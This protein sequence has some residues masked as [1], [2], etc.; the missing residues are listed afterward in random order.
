MRHNTQ[1]L[2]AAV[3]ASLMLLAIAGA[4]VAGPIEDGEAARDRKD[5][6][7]AL[8]LFRSLAE[9][10][11]PTAQEHLGVMYE[12]G[13]GLPQ[14]YAEAVLW[15]RRAAGQ[16]L[17]RNELAMISTRGS[18][19]A[20]A[21]PTPRAPPR[22]LLEINIGKPL[23]VGVADD[24][25]SVRPL[26]GPGRREA[27]LSA[28]LS[29]REPARRQPKWRLRGSITKARGCWGDASLLRLVHH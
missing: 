9:Q 17:P 10:G 29:V 6:A 12:N 3:T 14:D 7:T 2:R 23:P 27:A 24:E 15:Y 26:D 1:S 11:D 8:R 21:A 20:V 5:Y 4:V 13:Q 22:L 28:T 18:D 19:A 25:A 16:G